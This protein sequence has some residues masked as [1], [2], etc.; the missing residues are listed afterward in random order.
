[1]AKEHGIDEAAI[2]DRIHKLAEAVRGAD[3]E[4]LK[5]LYAP[6][7][8]SF[9]V[10]PRLQDV[11]IEAKL[12][13]WIAA[14]AVFQAPLGVEIRDVTITVG[15]DVAFGHG[16]NRLSG[17]MKNGTRTDGFWVR[18]TFCFRKIDGNWLIAHDHAS[19]PMDPGS[20][21]ALLNLEA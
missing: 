9:D 19:A 4:G 10:G 18:A 5:P 8:V 3:L 11:G 20:G 13:N 21:K 7:V 1:M 12:G 15:D 14:F 2:R 16:F 6:D 17:T